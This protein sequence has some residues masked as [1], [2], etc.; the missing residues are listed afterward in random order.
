MPWCPRCATGLSN[1]EMET[2]GYKD[3]THL[4]LYVRFP[5]T[6]RPGEYLLVWTTT[7]WTLAANVAAAVNPDL[8]YVK[9]EQ[10]GEYYY[11]VEQLL[12]VLKALK[13]RDKGEYRVVETLKGSDMVGWTYQGP[14]DELPAVQGTKHTVVPWK[15]ANATEGTGIVH[16]APGCGREDFGLSKDFGIAVIAPVDEFGVYL[17]GYDWLTG[18][19]ASEVGQLVAE[20]LTQKGLLYRPQ[21][22]RHRYPTC[23]RCKTE[24][25]FRLVDEWFIS[26]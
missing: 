12:P 15:E 22:Y 5:L 2:E 17:T 21:N 26:M 25:I 11:L 7:P 24:L 18:K 1:M 4:S 9:V 10:D 19:K 13:G 23:W 16:I 8:P 14:F 3:T 20:N 6:D